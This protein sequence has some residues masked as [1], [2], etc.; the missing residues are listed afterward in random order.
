M[1]KVYVYIY[2]YIIYLPIHGALAYITVWF[3]YL[4][5][6]WPP[7]TGPLCVYMSTVSGV[8]RFCGMTLD[9][10]KTF[11]WWNVDSGWFDKFFW[12]TYP[13]GKIYLCMILRWVTGFGVNFC[14][15][16]LYIK[17][18]R[19]Y[20]PVLNVH[21]ILRMWRLPWPWRRVTLRCPPSCGNCQTRKWP[22]RTQWP[23]SYRSAAR[24]SR[25]LHG[26]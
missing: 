10:F 20:S 7:G 1:C 6:Y 24:H 11:I 3:V 16:P 2:I 9:R 8:F 18:V 5:I 4:P 12:C 17:W 14:P 26:E 25:K 23:L 21:A 22:R 19:F 13:F 15:F